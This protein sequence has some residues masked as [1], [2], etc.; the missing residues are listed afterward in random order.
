MPRQDVRA[1]LLIGE[2]ML[3]GSKMQK[4]HLNGAVSSPVVTMCILGAAADGRC[5]A[6]IVGAE[7]V[8]HV[9]RPG[10]IHGSA[11]RASRDVGRKGR[12]GTTALGVVLV[13]LRAVGRGGG[14]TD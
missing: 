6:P 1:C 5:W 13:V 7:V 12:A 14:A 10:Y 11:R 8:I 3:F 2:M 9:M 4:V